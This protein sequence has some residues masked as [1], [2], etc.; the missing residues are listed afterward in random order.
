MKYTIDEQLKELNKIISYWRTY[1]E[2]ELYPMG[3]NY[4]KYNRELYESIKE[5][6]LSVK[7]KV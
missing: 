1:E 5:M 7:E 4:A 6:L 2:Y 3:K